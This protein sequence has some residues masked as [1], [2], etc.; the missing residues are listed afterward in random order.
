MYRA[1][2]I[3]PEATN[4]LVAGLTRYRPAGENLVSSQ[5]SGLNE[6]GKAAQPSTGKAPV[7]VFVVLLVMAVVAAGAA[8]SA[9]SRAGQEAA[10]MA[11]ESARRQLESAPFTARVTGI[12]ASELAI[13]PVEEGYRF[14]GI[15][16]G[17]NPSSEMQISPIE[18]GY[19]FPG[20]K[21]DTSPAPAF[22]M[23]QYG[24]SYFDRPET[25]QAL[26]AGLDVT[27]VMAI[28]PVEEG[29]RFPSEAYLRRREVM[30]A[31]NSDAPAGTLAAEIA[32]AEAAL[33]SAEAR[34]AELSSPVNG[35]TF[36]YW[37][38]A[39]VSAEVSQARK[40]LVQLRARQGAVVTDGS[41]RSLAADITAA[42]AALAV[43]EARLAELSSPINGETFK[44]WELA[45][46]SAEVSQARR[47]VE[48]LR[49][50]RR[51]IQ[52][53]EPAF[54][55]EVYWDKAA[56]WAESNGPPDAGEQTREERQWMERYWEHG[57]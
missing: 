19:R 5:T 53:G 14:P 6:L 30:K 41:A 55:T 40:N 34:L 2:G 7:V 44:Y 24:T 48:M 20:L 16:A 22:A 3:S 47:E 27:S 35:E 46:V 36:K 15:G 26:E 21:P 50:R 45:A 9:N 18:E 42:E 8:V 32:A 29:Y 38:L 49:A 52:M 56:E 57:R 39:A 4:P 1:D 25:L 43:A 10:R 13:S 37:E 33:A 51:L 54:S 23:P 31:R 11:S 28:S 12:P 17:A